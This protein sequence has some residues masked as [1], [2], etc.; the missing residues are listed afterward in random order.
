MIL[1]RGIY[2]T[3]TNTISFGLNKS[4]YA[5]YLAMLIYFFSG[6]FISS[7]LIASY[8]AASVKNDNKSEY[9]FT[10]RLPNI[11]PPKNDCP[12]LLLGSTSRYIIF[13]NKDSNKA[14]IIPIDDIAM[15]ERI[16]PEESD[17]EKPK[18]DNPKTNE[19]TKPPINLQ[20]SDS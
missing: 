20:K 14:Y 1:N 18:V 4:M 19:T 12:C 17:D 3:L 2:R 5:A 6:I 11:N 9:N 15:I 7:A 16:V 13:W 10:L 8:D